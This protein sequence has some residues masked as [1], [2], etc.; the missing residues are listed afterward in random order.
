METQGLFSVG[1]LDI[2]DILL[3]AFLIYKIYKMARGTT[4]VTIFWAISLLYAAW[5]AARA[6]NMEL[7]ST[8]LGQVTGVGLLAL[9]IVFQQEIRQ[10]QRCLLF[11]RTLGNIRRCELAG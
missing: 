9:L 8:I 11:K 7:I 10:Y 2:I 4:A 5:V 3:V 6:L 1:I